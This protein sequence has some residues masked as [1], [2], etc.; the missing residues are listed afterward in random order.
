MTKLV[1][2]IIS[3]VSDEKEKQILPESLHV[4]LFS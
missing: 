2:M 1:D 4:R 3:D